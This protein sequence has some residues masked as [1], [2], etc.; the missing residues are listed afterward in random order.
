MWA[1][2]SFYAFVG[3]SAFGGIINYNNT[4]LH[5]TTFAADDY[6]ANNFNDL[7]S[8]LVTLFE[9]LM[10]N[11]WHVIMD[12]CTAASGTEWS[13]LFF[14]SFWLITVV[15]M[16]NIV[17]ASI[18]E[19]FFNTAALKQFKRLESQAR[20]DFYKRRREAR[21][22]VALSTFDADAPSRVS[23]AETARESDSRSHAGIDVRR[24]AR[25]RGDRAV[26]RRK[27]LGAER[28][29]R[30]ARVRPPMSA[31]WTN[32][33]QWPRRAPNARSRASS[34]TRNRAASAVELVS[35]SFGSSGDEG[36]RGDFGVKSFSVEA[37]QSD[38]DS[39]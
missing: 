30:S 18:I 3:I 4:L 20:Q 32:R 9:L 23:G 14:V 36:R 24:G 11:N 25:F 8:A 6:W 13:R 29:L 17:V 12:G 39:L 1:A 15:I 37:S 7:A 21:L 28:G 34:S 27:P 33:S 35:D 26:R 19:G 31:S 5:N 16:T 10:V 22:S 2:V 38:S